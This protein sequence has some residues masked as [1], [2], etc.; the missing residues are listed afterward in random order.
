MSLDFE[1]ESAALKDG[2]DEEPLDSNF[3]HG[4]FQL[5]GHGEKTN[6]QCGYFSAYY[7]CVRAELH[8]I[9]TLHG[10]NYK[11]KA[12]VR[13]VFHSCDKPSCPICFRWGWAVREAMKVKWR[14]RNRCGSVSG[15]SSAAAGRNDCSRESIR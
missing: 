4:D 6:A 10:V 14:K 5:V 3:N 13:K 12:Y 9:I 15:T 1:K 8:N 2:N 7:G 11:K